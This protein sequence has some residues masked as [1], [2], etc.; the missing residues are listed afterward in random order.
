MLAVPASAFA[1]TGTTASSAQAP[2]TQTSP[3]QLQTTP[4]HVGFGSLATIR[5]TAPASYAGRQ[6]VLETALKPSAAWHVLTRTQIGSGGGFR[7]RVALRHSGVLRAV[8]GGEQPLARG[9][10]GA[11]VPGQ[12]TSEPRPVTVAA[13]FSVAS[14]RHA[15]LGGGAM[16]LAGKLLPARAGRSVVLQGHS[17]HGWKTLAGGRTG[18]RGSFRLHYTPGSALNRH[19][20]VKFAGDAANARTTRSA[21]T[22]TVYQPSVAS[23][24]DDAGSTACGYHSGLGVAN[25]SLPCG[26]KVQFRHGGRTVTATVDDRGPYVGGRE[27]DLNQNTAAAL[28]FSGVGTVWTAG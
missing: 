11:S 9:G 7:L 13:R 6:V 23:W 1:L 26:T 18:G 10:S 19:L 25:R 3:L 14:R 17:A 27:W 5:G 16:Q 28:G 24:Y 8:V 22:V 12:A 15:I 4:R 2:D 20:R 21:G